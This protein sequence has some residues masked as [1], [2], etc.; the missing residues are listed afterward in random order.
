MVE[1]RKLS[2]EEKNAYVSGLERNS[3]ELEYKEHLASQARIALDHGIR[4]EFEE[5]E[6]KTR[7]STQADLNGY[8]RSISEIKQI[9]A[10]CESK[11]EFGVPIRDVVENVSTS[12]EEDDYGR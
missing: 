3:Q 11:L 9:I 6:R 7:K 10:D 4:I 12:E 8:E 2:E 5:L 1:Y